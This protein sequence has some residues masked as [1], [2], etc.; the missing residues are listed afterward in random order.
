MLA[1]ILLAPSAWALSVRDYEN[2]TKEQQADSVANAID[3]I[4]ADVAKVDPALSRAIHD[5]FYVIPKGQPES[6]GLI[7]FA[8]VCWRLKGQPTT[9]GPTA[10]RCR[11]RE[12]CWA[13][14]SATS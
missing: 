5:Y 6:P 13:S 10:T 12:S 7:A 3:K 2:A 14:S 9:E 4:I 8:G 11:S 1:A